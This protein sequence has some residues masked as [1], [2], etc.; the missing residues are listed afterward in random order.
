VGLDAERVEGKMTE[1]R[2]QYGVMEFEQDYRKA[3]GIN[4]SA[5]CAGLVSMRHMHHCMTGG[6]RAD[7]AAMAWGRRAHMAVLQPRMWQA[8][9]AVW[10]GSRKAGKD[11]EAALSM[12][13]DP[14][15][16][17]TPNEDCE[18]NAMADSVWANSDAA[19]LLNGVTTERPI[20][21]HDQRCGASKARTDADR[22][23]YLIDYKTARNIDPASFFR[24]CHNLN[25]VMRMGWY[26]RA[27]EVTTGQRPD[28]FLIVQESAAPWDCYPVH[29]KPSMISDG[30]S[31][32][33]EIAVHYRCCE[34][35]GVFPGVVSGVAEYE[36]PAWAMANE[37][38]DPNA[39]TTGE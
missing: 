15:L 19:W 13:S 36:P 37:D 38:F 14:D 12:V 39:T 21:W 8:N 4:A 32:A 20:Y 1:Q 18:L 5:I 11:W 30:E 9:R 34:Q 22:P 6:E 7:T 16:I 33:V 29:I 28:V 3:P 26:A 35:S 24:S 31:E 27:I 2:E 25:Y 10:V 17:V 23:G